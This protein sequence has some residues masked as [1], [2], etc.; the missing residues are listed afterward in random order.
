MLDQLNFPSAIPFL[1][2][3]LALDRIL[4][5]G[6]LLEVDEL[7]HLIL[8]GEA[9]HGVR[10]VFVHAADEIVRHADVQR[11]AEFAGEDVYPEDSLPAHHQLPGVLDCPLPRAMTPR[12]RLPR[13]RVFLHPSAHPSSSA[14]FR[15]AII[16]IRS[17]YSRVSA[18]SAAILRNSA[19]KCACS[20]GS[21]L[22]RLRLF[23]IVCFCTYSSVTRRRCR[24]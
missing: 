19:R 13:E 6:K 16:D 23:W 4:D 18:G 11:P 3:L 10:A 14:R 9:G 21:L 20:A 1:E 8:L 17:K 5:I 24:S 22:S 2:Q 7:V 12:V 15:L